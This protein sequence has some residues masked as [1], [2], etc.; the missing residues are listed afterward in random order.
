MSA[1]EVLDLLSVPDSTGEDSTVRGKA[2]AFRKEVSK[3][4]VKMLT[5]GCYSFPACGPL[6]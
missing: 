2:A 5:R 3:H 6:D 4:F 1:S